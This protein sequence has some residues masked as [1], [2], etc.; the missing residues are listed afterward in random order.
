MAPALD[1]LE[2]IAPW[3]EGR[4][5]SSAMTDPQPT[6]QPTT[7]EGDAEAAPEFERVTD[8]LGPLE[9]VVLAADQEIGS[10]QER[11]EDETGEMS[12]Q[13]DVRVR[14]AAMEQRNRV[15]QMREALT[16][17]ATEL[18]TR[19]DAMLKILDQAERELAKQGLPEGQTGD[20]ASDVRVTVTERRR[21]TIAH[22]EPP[23]AKPDAPGP[24]PL[25]SPNLNL[26]P[27]EEE[28]KGIRRW[29]RRFKRSAA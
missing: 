4:G 6:T 1:S 20:G 8:V 14:E 17:R 5:A 10:I 2:A 28:G 3:H 19:F 18:A 24:P 15:L 25:E 7:L 29:F 13:V 27:K 11:V 9:Q 23:S 16:S 21:V 12:T 22:D 26:Q